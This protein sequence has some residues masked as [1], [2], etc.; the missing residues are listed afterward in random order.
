MP[1][2]SSETAATR[3]NQSSFSFNDDCTTAAGMRV[4]HRTLPAATLISSER[5]SHGLLAQ[6]DLRLLVG[7]RP[8]L[9]QHLGPHEAHMLPI[10]TLINCSSSSSL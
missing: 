7:V 4:I 6:G 2:R 5:M 1:S 3:K 10:S 9:A 8:N